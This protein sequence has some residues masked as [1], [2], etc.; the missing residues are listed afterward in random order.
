VGEREALLTAVLDTPHD[1]TPRLVFADRSPTVWPGIRQPGGA[2][3][4][5]IS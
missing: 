3:A 2:C 4:S 1:D 5:D